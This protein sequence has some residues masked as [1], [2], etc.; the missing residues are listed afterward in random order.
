LWRP[1]GTGWPSDDFILRQ[2]NDATGKRF[3]KDRK[4]CVGSRSGNSCLR[5]DV[6]AKV[7]AQKGRPLL[8]RK[9]VLGCLPLHEAPRHTERAEGRPEQH[10]CGAAIWDR[11][12]RMR[13]RAALRAG[14]LAK[15]KHC[16]TKDH[17]DQREF[18]YG[19]D[20]VFHICHISKQV[21]CQVQIVIDTYINKSDDGNVLRL[22]NS[23]CCRLGAVS[24]KRYPLET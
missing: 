16:G 17:S 5:S 20:I 24:S 4:D 21:R 15:R 22:F 11:N 6:Q 19:N 3:E 8:C 14:V 1:S 12:C 9:T 18:P 13:H 10:D 2:R 7:A 23:G